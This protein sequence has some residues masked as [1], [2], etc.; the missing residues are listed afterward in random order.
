MGGQATILWLIRHL[1]LVISYTLMLPVLTLAFSYFTEK[2]QQSYYQSDKYMLDP[3]Q[4]T[5]HIVVTYAC[6]IGSVIL[7]LFFSYVQLSSQEVPISFPEQN[8]QQLNSSRI[9]YALNAIQALIPISCSIYDRGLVRSNEKL[10]YI[11]VELMESIYLASELYLVF[12]CLAY[13]QRHIVSGKVFNFAIQITLLALGAC[14]NILGILD[15]NQVS[16]MAMVLIPILFKALHQYISQQHFE[17]MLALPD[18]LLD[19]QILQLRSQYLAGL[20]YKL[21]ALIQSKQHL[22][23]KSGLSF[24][25][26]A[27]MVHHS[28]LCKDAFCYCKANNAIGSYQVQ[29]STSAANF[30]VLLETYDRYI[31]H[32]TKQLKRVIDKL[33]ASQNHERFDSIVQYLLILN[34]QQQ[35]FKVV[36]EISEIVN[37]RYRGDANIPSKVKINIDLIKKLA[38]HSI[39]ASTSWNCD[40]SLGA[41]GLATRAAAQPDCYTGDGVIEYIL[42]QKQRM[43]AHDLLLRILRGRYKFLTKY[44]GQEFKSQKEFYTSAFKILELMQNFEQKL[45]LTIFQTS[46]LYERKL[47]LYYYC[48][49]SEDY[50]QANRLVA[51]IK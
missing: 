27:Q 34:S 15:E 18:V 43:S 37:E 19:K 36:Q 23:S 31:Y 8:G 10:A 9:N 16:L 21:S 4:E 42:A 30:Q 22:N 14:R 46:Q 33:Q 17:L 47:L 13:S 7:V 2:F 41:R 26:L 12:S 45:K 35:N 3:R 32:L 51:E 6:L 20:K 39:K 24:R 40:Q 48:E 29:A 44:R 49:I 1:Q 50:I 5:G 38:Q 28:S 25:V 11:L